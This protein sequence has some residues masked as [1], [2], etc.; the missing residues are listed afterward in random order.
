M[1]QKSH[2]QSYFRRVVLLW[3]I[4]WTIS[5]PFFH[6]HPEADH[7]HGEVG[8]QHGGIAHTVFSTDLGCEYTVTAH[9]RVSE[10]SRHQYLHPTQPTHAFD[11][12][13]IEFTLLS[14]PTD[15]SL[16]RSGVT[17]SALPEIAI[18]PPQQTLSQAFLSPLILP[19]AQYVVTGAPPRAPPVLSV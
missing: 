17:G 13:E 8:H 19:V 16:D 5:L 9:D 15:R 10:D 6:I 3:G 7:H 14:E 2:N 11:H 4:F 18:A 12:P 1:T